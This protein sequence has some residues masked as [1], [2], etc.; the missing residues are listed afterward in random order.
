MSWQA[1]L[2]K[3]NLTHLLLLT[4]VGGG[5]VHV[6]FCDAQKKGK[7]HTLQPRPTLN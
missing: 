3:F 6:D 5:Q 2:L 4:K 1:Q 7:T